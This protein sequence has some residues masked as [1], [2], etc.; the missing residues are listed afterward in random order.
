MIS[1]NYIPEKINEYNVYLDGSKMIGVASSH[2]LPEVNMQ[3]STVSGMGVNGEV[4]SPTLGQFESME[5]E[6]QF[7]TLYSSAVD[8]LNPMNAIN[9]TF[10]AAQQVYDKSTGGGYAF[11]SL[12]IVEMGR[13][14]KFKPGKIEKAESMEATITLELTYLLVEVD[15]VVVMEIDKLNQVYNVNGVDMLADVRNM[16]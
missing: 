10:R 5:Q 14:K 1:D 16:T 7:N 11:K 15:G 12:R 3:T 2:T 4:D 9:L 8:M 6:I 13:V